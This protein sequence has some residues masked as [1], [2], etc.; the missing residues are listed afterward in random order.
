MAS[1]RTRLK[2]GIVPLIDSAPVVVAKERGFFAEAGLDVEISREASWAS[3]RDKLAVGALD[4]AQMLATM[5]LSMTLGLGAIRTDVLA[6]A[7]LNLGGNTIVLSAALSKRLDD[8]GGPV[9]QALKAIIQADL[10]AGKPPMALAMVYPFSTHHYELRYWL[11][12]AGI[13]PDRHVRLTVV[14]PPQMVAHLSAGNIAGFCVGEPWGGLAASMELGRV[15]ATSD[16]VFGGRL[17]K[18]LGVTRTFAEANPDTVTAMIKAVVSAAAWCDANPAETAEILAQPAYVNVPLDVARR[19]LQAPVA[20]VFHAFAANFPWRSQAMWFLSQMK[21]WKQLGDGID[22]RRVAE[23]VYRPD[24]YR[25][26]ALELGLPV[27]LTDHKTEGGHDAPWLFDK[28]T[29]PIIMG[30]D[31]FLDGARFDPFAT[32]PQPGPALKETTP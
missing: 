11:A 20:P 28:A 10:A 9:P 23:A 4:G 31:L 3:I 13:D 17:E 15:V 8:V 21:R 30:P 7:G 27:P 26:A 29:A 19:S 16:Q 14:P 25:L 24:L 1:E 2:L 22:S 32:A 12:A 5:P 6:V 18:V